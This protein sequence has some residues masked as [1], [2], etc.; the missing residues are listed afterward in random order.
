MSNGDRTQG[1]R[2][3]SLED[4]AQERKEDT[5]AWRGSVEKRFDKIDKKLDSLLS[6]NKNVV[7][8]PILAEAMHA[9]VESCPS[10]NP[11]NPGPKNNT[12]GNKWLGLALQ[13]WKGLGI[14]GSMVVLN[15]MLT[16]IILK[17]IKVF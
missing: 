14:I 5:T 17:L 10:R 6:N 4:V 3:T 11:S 7:T 9:H 16:I 8:L 1:E 2:I 13:G 15:G 12:N